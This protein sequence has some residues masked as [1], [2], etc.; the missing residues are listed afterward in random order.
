MTDRPAAGRRWRLSMTGLLV[1]TFGSLVAASVLLVLGFAVWTATR[2]TVD[3]LRDRADLRIGI[4]TLEI[5]HLLDAARAQADF[6]ARALE[7]GQVDP[8]DRERLGG[9]LF[10][11]MAADPAIGALAYLH[12][13][14]RA[15][16]AGRRNGFAELRER[17]F[18]ADRAARPAASTTRSSATM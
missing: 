4:L 10:G 5:D 15:H 14:G 13:D 17:D 16:I 3:L 2:N 6:A 8:D 9:F 1:L 18:S 11:A 7:T 12:R